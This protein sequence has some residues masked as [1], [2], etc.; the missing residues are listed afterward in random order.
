MMAPASLIKVPMLSRRSVAQA[1]RGTCYGNSAAGVPVS[2]VALAKGAASHVIGWKTGLVWQKGHHHDM[3]SQP[4]L[5]A[6][7]MEDRNSMSFHAQGPR[8]FSRERSRIACRMDLTDSFIQSFKGLN[9]QSSS[10]TLT[11]SF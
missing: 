3:S 9:P 2:H 11:A 7:E 6:S 4:P 1:A 10:G 5:V 8:L